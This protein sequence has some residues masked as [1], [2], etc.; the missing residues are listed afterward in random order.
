MSEPIDWFRRPG[1]DDPGTLNAC[2][3]ALDRHV[4]RGRAD[5]VALVADRDYSYSRLLTEA[6]ACAGALQALGV[7]V[8]DAVLLEG[9]PPLQQVVGTLACARLGAVAID[10]AAGAAAQPALAVVGTLADATAGEAPVITVDETGELTWETAMTA[11][12]TDPAACAD[13][14]ADL[15]LRVAGGRPVPTGEHLL[16]VAASEVDDP[17]LGPLLAG[18]TLR[19]PA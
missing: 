8:G 12:R 3:N 16:A 13:V 6:S 10:T 4:I 14:R 1:A 18:G 9:L 15:P 11:G 17:V 2:Y 5:E 7:G 19:L